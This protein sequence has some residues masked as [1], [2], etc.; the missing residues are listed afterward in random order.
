MYLREAGEEGFIFEV[1]PS[2]KSSPKFASQSHISPDLP[3]KD[4]LNLQL[5]WEL[6]THL[7]KER[8]AFLKPICQGCLNPGPPLPAGHGPVGF[9]CSHQPLCHPQPRH[10]TW[11]QA[12]CSL[13]CTC[14]HTITCARPP[15]EDSFSSCN[16]LSQCIRDTLTN[17]YSFW[18]YS[19]IRDTQQI[20]VGLCRFHLSHK[21]S[22][23]A[24][25]NSLKLQ[26]RC[27]PSPRPFIPAPISYR[28][29][30]H[31]QHLTPMFWAA[32]VLQAMGIKSFPF[33]PQAAAPGF[34]C[35]V[36]IFRY[37]G[38]VSWDRRAVC[39]SSP[40]H[41]QWDSHWWQHGALRIHLT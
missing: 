11:G 32:R 37:K 17:P 25:E 15:G 41:E 3:A 6:K 4:L 30:L 19:F 27:P 8:E 13:S 18:E 21:R 2:F 40:C 22:R 38:C 16:C 33:S 10:V 24:S 5:S 14:G 7:R 34:L 39:F 31:L 9:H 12:P 28:H 1:L 36:N 26:Q 23:I 35:T 20:C 29:S